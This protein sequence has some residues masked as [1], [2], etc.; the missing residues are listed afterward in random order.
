M[1]TISSV[2][3][4]LQT[5]LQKINTV[6]KAVPAR[7]LTADDASS[8]QTLS[9][10][11]LH[12]EATQTANTHIALRNN[13]HGIAAAHLGGESKAYVDDKL[14]GKIRWDAIGVSF[15]GDAGDP[16]PS[17]SVD[18]DTL[19]IAGGVAAL[20]Q[21]KFK[22]LPAW[23]VDL[24]TIRPS[25][26]PTKVHIHVVTSGG[27]VQ[28]RATAT[29]LPES[30]GVMWIGS[31]L[32]DV[33]SVN[34]VVRVGTHRLSELSAG[35]AI[36]VTS[37]SPFLPGKIDS[38]FVPVTAP[39]LFY[40]TS[41]ERII[42]QSYPDTTMNSMY[43]HRGYAVAHAFPDDTGLSE[44]LGGIDSPVVTINTPSGP[45]TNEILAVE[46]I[47]EY[48]WES[49]GVGGA[50]GTAEILMDGYR[51]FVRGRDPFPP[52]TYIVYYGGLSVQ[53]STAVDNRT[54]ASNP[55][56]STLYTSMSVNAPLAV[57]IT[58]IG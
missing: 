21:G 40:I 56:S 30:L 45:I 23:S 46:V 52:G 38:G 26:S 49:H 19:N 36:P 33:A 42:T 18:G 8:L 28:Y 50:G 13:P 20:V 57:S 37:G 25:G 34:R 3:T 15:Y 29:P 58:K 9:A 43:R 5:L 39:A 1:G 55:A 11:A 32:S 16:L 44:P 14:S 10:S 41:M 17:A 35:S 24:S 47:H 51:F 48:L 6:A 31:V 7:S 53:V 2:A 54:L 12:A 4:K 27:D 22:V